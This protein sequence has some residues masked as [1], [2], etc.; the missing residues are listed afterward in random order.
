[1]KELFSRDKRLAYY[2]RKMKIKPYHP[3]DQAEIVQLLRLN[4][5]EY[6]APSE[7]SDLMD[8]FQHH[9]DHYYVVEMDGKIV[10]CGGFNLADEGKTAR[11]S[12]DIIHPEY[13][14]KGIGGVLTS[15][16]IEEI[17]KIE[18]VEIISVR[19]SQLVYPFYEKFGFELKE[20]VKDY[21]AKGFDL[22]RMERLAVTSS[23]DL[24]RIHE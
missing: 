14:G 2:L 4:T 7:E 21:W 11:I 23:G 10:G 3:S 13:Q 9:I 8:Y 6:F 5:P 17:G 1:M 19:T 20:V 18:S 15:F 12:W 22:Y 16:R 24:P